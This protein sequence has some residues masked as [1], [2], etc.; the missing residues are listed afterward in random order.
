MIPS[1]VETSTLGEDNLLRSEKAD[2]L[3][4]WSVR[5]AFGEQKGVDREE[6]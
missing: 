6:D 3:I 4:V 1:G 5:K 2:Y